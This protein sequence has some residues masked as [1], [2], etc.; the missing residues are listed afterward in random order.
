MSR[1]GPGSGSRRGDTMTKAQ[2]RE[3]AQRRGLSYEAL[4]ADAAAQGIMLRDD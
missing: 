3:L 1:Q 2:L 4:L